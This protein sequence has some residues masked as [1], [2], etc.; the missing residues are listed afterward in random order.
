MAYPTFSGSKSESAGN[1]LDDLEMAFIIAERDNEEVKVRAF[2]L[3][4][5]ETAK[6]W[7][8]GLA[9]DRKNGWERIKEAFLAEYGGRDNPRELWKRISSLQQETLG[10]Y[11]TYEAQF[12]KM[13]TEWEASL[14]QGERTPD[15]LQMEKFLEGLLP[16]LREKVKGKF[17]KTFQEALQ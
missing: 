1:F 2:P 5:K 8:Q 10:S 12:L 7:F 3:V 13:W 15:L 14:P 6:T 17:P 11:Q 4:L 9:A 16:S